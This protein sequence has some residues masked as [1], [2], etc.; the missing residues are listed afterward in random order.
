MIIIIVYLY[1]GMCVLQVETCEVNTLFI[2]HV[3]QVLRQVLENGSEEEEVAE[4]LGIVSI[5]G[6]ILSITR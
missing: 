2:E 5:E 4:H 6:L 3:I 1:I